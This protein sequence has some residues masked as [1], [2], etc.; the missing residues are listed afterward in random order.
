MRK[1]ALESERDPN[2]IAVSILV[3]SIG[4]D[5]LEEWDP[6]GWALRAKHWKAAGASH[7]LLSTL[8]LGFSQEEHLEALESFHQAWIEVGN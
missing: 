4:F 1:A 5:E 2:R 3:S 6:I 7:A 8:D